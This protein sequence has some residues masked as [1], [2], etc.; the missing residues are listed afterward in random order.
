[1]HHINYEINK[2]IHLPKS[3]VHQNVQFGAQN[4]ITRIVGTT[5]QLHLS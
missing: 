1:M 2:N 5:K 3:V 4:N